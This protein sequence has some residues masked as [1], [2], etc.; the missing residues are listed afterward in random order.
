MT[1]TELQTMLLIL[2]AP[3]LLMKQNTTALSNALAI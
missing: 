1:D 3:L 2:P